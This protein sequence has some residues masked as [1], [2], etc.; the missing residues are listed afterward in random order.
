MSSNLELVIYGH[1]EVMISKFNLLDYFGK[2]NNGDLKDRFNNLYPVKIKNNL[3]YIYNYKPRKFNNINKYYEMG[4]NN[5]R[6]NLLDEKD[7][8]KI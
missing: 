1:E 5:L 8:P 3:M 7:P 4:I 2:N 6:I